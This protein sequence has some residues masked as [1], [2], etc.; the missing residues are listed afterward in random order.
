MFHVK[1]FYRKHHG[2]IGGNISFAAALRKTTYLCPRVWQNMFDPSPKNVPQEPSLPV[3]PRNV[4][5]GTILFSA[6]FSSRRSFRQTAPKFHSF[7]P[8]SFNASQ[9][10]FPMEPTPHTKFSP[11]FSPGSPNDSFSVFFKMFHVKHFILLSSMF[12]VKHFLSKHH[13]TI[14][15]LL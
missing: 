11:A 13:K 8:L 1:H 6:A 2:V 4:S 9:R 14:R 3:F 10:I 5:R 12:H 15:P 7:S